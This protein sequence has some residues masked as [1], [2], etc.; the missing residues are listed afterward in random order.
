[1]WVE[2]LKDDLSKFPES[3]PV[4]L[5]SES[6]YKVLLNPTIHRRSARYLYSHPDEI[7]I[8]PETNRLGRPLMPLYRHWDY[9]LSDERNDLYSARLVSLFR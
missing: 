8:T 6:L 7:P 1:M 3:F 5:T 2:E 9:R 4:L